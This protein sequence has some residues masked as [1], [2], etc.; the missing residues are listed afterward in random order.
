MPGHT[1]QGIK[2]VGSRGRCPKITWLHTHHLYPSDFSISIYGEPAAALEQ[3]IESIRQHGILVPLVVSRG[4]EAGRW[5]ILSGH[6]RW[7]CAQKLQIEQVPCEVRSSRSR[8]ARQYLVLEYNRQRQKTFSQLMREADALEKIYA[9]DARA[10][11][12]ANLRLHVAGDRQMAGA[13]AMSDRRN[14][15][16]RVNQVA[17]TSEL[18]RKSTQRGRTDVAVAEHLGLG[19]KDT[20]R[21]ARAVWQRACHGDPRAQDGVKQLDAGTKTIHAAYKDLRRRERFAM[22]FRPTPYDVWAFRRNRAFGLSYP[23]STPAGIIAHTLYYFAPIGGL[24]VDPMAGGGTTLDVCQAMGRR[25]LAYDLEPVRPDIQQHDARQGFPDACQDCDLIFCDPPYHTMLAHRYGVGSVS[26]MP[27]AEWI[28]FLQRFTTTAFST[29]RPGGYLALLLAP[30]TEKDLPP[31]YGYLDHVFFSY[32]AAVRAG[33][34]P[35]RRI[36]CPMEVAYLPQ[37]IQRART[38]RRLLGQVR[39]LLVVRKPSVAATS[40]GTTIPLTRAED[41]GSAIWPKLTETPRSP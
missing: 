5:E 6:R 14:S 29:L 34:L 36:S 37:H 22:D 11:R 25:C 15:D 30:Q 20:Y 7:A 35:E 33:F 27:L 32:I 28:E 12:L 8:T 19:S 13:V 26:E 38:E 17:E 21:Q 24:V 16:D 39:D 4:I 40:A 9:E 41:C 3:L 23:G 18:L 10:R 31:G 2:L 1:D